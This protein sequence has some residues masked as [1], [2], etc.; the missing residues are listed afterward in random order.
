MLFRSAIRRCTRKL[1]FEQALRVE[2][3][4]KERRGTESA[5]GGGERGQ[6]EYDAPTFDGEEAESVG[7]LVRGWVWDCESR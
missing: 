6:L 7:V 1:L 4:P 3:L 5:R 2:L